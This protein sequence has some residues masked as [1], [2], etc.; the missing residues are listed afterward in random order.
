MLQG[1]SCQ[2]WLCLSVTGR[3]RRGS[4][5]QLSR[6]A[7]RVAGQAAPPV[8]AVLVVAEGR[9]QVA[10]VATLPGEVESSSCVNPSLN[11]CTM[12]AGLPNTC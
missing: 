7:E 8:A 11:V 12:S 10:E 3:E 4:L 5:A 9:T 6:L 1:A 2:Q